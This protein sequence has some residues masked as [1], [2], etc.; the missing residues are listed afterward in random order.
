MQPPAIAVLYYNKTRLTQ[1]CIQSVIQSGYD[2]AR[3]YAFDNGSAE[4]S[5]IQIKHLFPGIQHHRSP[6]N[7]GY[8]GGF[9]RCLAWVYQFPGDWVLFLTNDTCILPGAPVNCVIAGERNDAS[10][11]APLIVYQS[12]P[13]TIDSNGAFFN[14]DTGS[15]H[16]Y[17]DR[18]LSPCLNPETDYI[19]GTALCIHRSAF[20]LLGG[21]DESFHTYWEDADMCFRA[22]RKGIR[23]TRSE[24]AVIL[25]G[26]GRTCHKKPM[27]TTFLYQR[28]R[29]R[30]C[31][32][33]VD[34]QRLP[35]VMESIRRDLDIR[36]AKCRQA[37]DR[38]RLK[39]L[40]E[41]RKE[42]DEA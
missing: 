34:S 42:L 11:V 2:P 14:S 23:L 18:N 26:V 25:H 6:E 30:F 1:A 37:G 9:N 3:I 4:D 10:M 20:E 8:S 7:T 21:V 15:L 39:L 29:I 12:D 31:R 33:Y 32:K 24:D 36:E 17:H 19:P 27:Y 22:H 5:F 35:A 28:N 40:G 16:H 38:Q 13:D 41:V